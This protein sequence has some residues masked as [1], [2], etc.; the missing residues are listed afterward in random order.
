MRRPARGTTLAELLVALAVAAIV[1]APL[2]RLMRTNAAASAVAADRVAVERDAD[3]ALERIAARVRATT[4][5]LLAPNADSSTSGSW[6]GA[7]TFQL[8]SGKLVETSG[9]TS[10]TLADNVTAFSI[11]P[12]TVL[13]G[14]QLVL[15]SVTLARGDASTTHS[16]TVRMGGPR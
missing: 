11:T 15:A 8:S 2:A 6:F 13:T 5:A 4:P 3:F 14:Q 12:N 7:V 16:A 9:A 10:R 1:L